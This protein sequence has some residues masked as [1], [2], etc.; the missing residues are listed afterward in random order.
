ME[1][2]MLFIGIVAFSFSFFVSALHHIHIYQLN[3]YKDK[4]QLNW[5]KK[6]KKEIVRKSSFLII[7][8]PFLMFAFQ[9]YVMPV[10][11]S[12]ILVAFGIA[13]KPKNVKKP[14]VYTNRIKRLIATLGIIGYGLVLITYLISKSLQLSLIIMDILV[15]LIPLFVLF[16][17]LINK[18]INYAINQ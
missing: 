6:N 4:V 8:L 10:I 13:N 7:A 18:P 15:L 9:S 11:L 17:N 3:Y 5:I 14:L 16:A 2:I 12:I 1:Y